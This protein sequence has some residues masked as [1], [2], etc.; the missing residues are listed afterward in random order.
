MEPDFGQLLREDRSTTVR[1]RDSLKRQVAG[2]VEASEWTANDDEHDPE[3]STIAYER[4]QAQGLL[5]QA[6]ADLEAL[7][8]AEERLRD[9]TY[10]TCLHCG[11][12]IGTPRLEALPATTSCISCADRR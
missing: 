6:Q 4:A 3:G 11:R 8:R 7:D 12:P 10:G 1:L 9:G 2:I 5:R